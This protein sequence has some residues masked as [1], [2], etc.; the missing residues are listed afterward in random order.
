METGLRVNLNTVDYKFF[1][2]DNDDDVVTCVCCTCR[3]T[4]Q[5]SLS[6]L[7]EFAKGQDG[8]LAIAKERHVEGMYIIISNHVQ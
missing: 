8:E 4:N 7:S 6:T 2:N 1:P 3:K 5:L